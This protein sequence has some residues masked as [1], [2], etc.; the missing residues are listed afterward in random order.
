MLGNSNCSLADVP[1]LRD[2]RGRGRSGWRTAPWSA[3]TNW[4]R[5]MWKLTALCLG[6][7]LIGSIPFGLLLSKRACR[8][9]PRSVG[10]GNIGAANVCRANGLT[11]GCLTLLCDAAK[12]WLPTWTALHASF[13]PWAISLV[14]L[15]AF[16]GHLFPCYLSFKGGKGVATGAGAFLVLSPYAMVSCLSLFVVV[17]ALSRRISAGS[18]LAF[19]ALPFLV[20][21]FHGP[22]PFVGLALL[23]CLGVVIKHRDNVSRLIRGTEPSWR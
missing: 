17:V 22:R 3:L 7:Y 18:L 14:A 15:C 21:C 5:N 9:D 16:L 2:A 10:S 20:W 1:R 11:L 6:A 13:S 8:Q 19:T 23:L 4:A 12:G